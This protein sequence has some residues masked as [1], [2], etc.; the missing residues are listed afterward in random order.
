MYFKSFDKKCCLLQI[1]LAMSIEVSSFQF[2]LCTSPYLLLLKRHIYTLEC[3]YFVFGMLLNDKISLILLQLYN[4]AGPSFKININREK[5]PIISTRKLSLVIP[6]RFEAFWQAANSV[7]INLLLH[8]TNFQ[9]Y[10]ED[11]TPMFQTITDL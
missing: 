3:N 4:S 9:L 8:L 10:R 7:K 6:I 11:K 1:F 2:I 5:C